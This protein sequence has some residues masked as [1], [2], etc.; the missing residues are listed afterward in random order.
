MTKT[1]LRKLENMLTSLNDTLKYLNKESLVIC[2]TSL[3][4]LKSFYNDEGLGLTPMEKFVGSELVYLYTIKSDLK[5][6]IEEE[7]NKQ[8]KKKI[9]N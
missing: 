5:S 8:S 9:H 4:T 7:K 1:Q 2:T 6:M 3:P